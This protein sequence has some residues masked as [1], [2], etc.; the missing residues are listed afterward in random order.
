MAATGAAVGPE[1]AD[2]RYGK[3]GLAACGRARSLGTVILAVVLFQQRRYLVH[4]Q[5]LIEQI[6]SR[7]RGIRAERGLPV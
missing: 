2:A 7:V 6:V 3:V 4:N 1:Y 5:Q